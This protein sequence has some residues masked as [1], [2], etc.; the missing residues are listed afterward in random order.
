MKFKLFGTMHVANE[1]KITNDVREFASDVDAVFYEDP[2]ESSTL[3]DAIFAILRNPCV[4]FGSIIY[5]FLLAGFQYF[6][7]QP[8]KGLER[9][10]AENMQSEFGIE[11]H[12]VDINFLQRVRGA[13]IIT[14]I[15][16]WCAFLVSLWLLLGTVQLLL[17][18][19]YAAFWGFVFVV[20]IW[21]FSLAIFLWV[22]NNERNTTMYAQITSISDSEQYDSVCL[23]AGDGHI[24][25]IGKLAQEDGHAVESERR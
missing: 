17:Q 19:S 7:T 24:S 23:L 3:R 14:T 20:A 25:P 11:I 22:V 9:S 1:E 4:A 5:G 18:L 10:V 6:Q 16:S 12:P 21:G 2:N 13:H 8:D 15:F